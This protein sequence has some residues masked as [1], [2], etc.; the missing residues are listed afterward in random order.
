LLS[1]LFRSQLKGKRH[2]FGA[3]ELLLSSIFFILMV[4]TGC[5]SSSDNVAR[6]SEY[7]SG[8]TTM[9][10]LT[11][12][13][14]DFDDYFVDFQ[15]EFDYNA[16]G[17]SVIE[18]KKPSEIEGVEVV[19][20]DDEITLNYD[21]VSL[22]MGH[23]SHSAL[24]P[25]GA[26]PELLRV[27]QDGMVSEQ[28]IEKIDGTECIFILHKSSANGVEVQYSTWFD[29]NSLKPIKAEIAVDGIRKIQC[30]YLIAGKFE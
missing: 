8:L 4:L 22:E 30:E 10:V 9:K 5:S 27:W 26:I 23:Y 19:F 29:N 13:R 3:F 25:V 28:G 12:V 18:V 17:R 15:L 6:V 21:G 14:A 2:N 11:D 24:S 16:L 20:G 1:L 7:Y